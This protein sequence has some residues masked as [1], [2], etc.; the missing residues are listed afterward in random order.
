VADQL[1]ITP[2]VDVADLVYNDPN[3][4]DLASWLNNAGW[5]ATE[6][7][8]QDEMRRLGRWTE[9]P[10]PDDASSSFVLAERS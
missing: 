5:R 1:G 6:V 8:A 7:R 2:S 10:T 9:L 4:T 3:R